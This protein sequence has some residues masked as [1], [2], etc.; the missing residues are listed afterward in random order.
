MATQGK[1]PFHPDEKTLVVGLT[2][3]TTEV[4]KLDELA[5]RHRH[6]RSGYAAYLLAQVIEKEYG[7]GAHVGELMF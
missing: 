3:T 7:K 1:K 4:A 2:L 5:R 6:S